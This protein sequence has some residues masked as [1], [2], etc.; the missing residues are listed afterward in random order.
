[1]YQDGRQ[2]A[3]HGA[4]YSVDNV[5]NLPNRCE[6][7]AHSVI[8]Q[9]KIQ[10]KE[11]KGSPISPLDNQVALLMFMLAH[12]IADAHMPF[13]CDSRQFS[14]GVDLHSYIEGKW[15]DEIKN[16]YSIDEPNNRFFYDRHG[17]PEKTDAANINVSFLAD[18][19][20][21]LQNRPF[22]VGYGQ[23]NANILEFMEAV[24]QYSYLISYEFIPQ[25]FDESNVTIQNY[26]NLPGQRYSY[27]EL[28]VMAF[29]DAI[30]SLARA[31]FRVWRRYMRWAWGS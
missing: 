3:L 8:D 5:T 30:D 14:Q 26:H 18:L 29:A 21:E 23:T 20:Q 25:G 9:L 12:Y 17:F 22:R 13:H 10:E 4:A 31:W 16:F 1:M 24:C 7:L 28:S 11:V 6:A 15:E 2:S 27:K 19:D